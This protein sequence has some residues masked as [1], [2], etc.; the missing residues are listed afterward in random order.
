MS[1]E[2]APLVVSATD[3]I[4]TD[5]P[6]WMNRGTFVIATVGAAIG[7]GNVWRFP[8]LSFKHGGTTFIWTYLY[9][10]FIIGIPML[11]LELTLGQKM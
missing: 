8:Y 6:R 9:A 4:A 2:P 7:V 10:L 3:D 5:R 1:V 11:I